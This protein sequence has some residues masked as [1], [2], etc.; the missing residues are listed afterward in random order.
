[1]R[2]PRDHG[3]RGVLEAH[4]LRIGV[5]IYPTD[6]TEATTLL[7]NAD[8]AMYKAKRKGSHRFRFFTDADQPVAAAD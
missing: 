3:Q 5:A 4:R 7:K 1:M 6:G 8:V 2:R